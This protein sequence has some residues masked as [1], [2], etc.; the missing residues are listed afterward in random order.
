L[1]EI[2]AID[3]D[4]ALSLSTKVGPVTLGI[5]TTT[6]GEVSTLVSKTAV[7]TSSGVVTT[8]QQQLR[9]HRKYP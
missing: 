7:G 5:Y 4:Y 3:T 1:I 9:Y 2:S 6:G 8:V